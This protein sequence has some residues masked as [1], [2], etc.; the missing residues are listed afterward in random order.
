MTGAVLPVL[1]RTLERVFSG[2]ASALFILGAR[3]L[4]NANGFL[5]TAIVAYHYGLGAVGTL[6][7]ATVP[8][9][10][11]ALFGTFGLPFRFAQINISHA[12]CNS[13]G[14][15]SAAISLPLVLVM[16]A[17]FGLA[18]G[19]DP[20]E[21]FNLAAL[22]FSA[23]FF[24]QTNV[25][26]A[27]QVLQ[28]REAQSI[29]APALNAIGLL[30]GALMPDFTSF[31]ISVL[32]FR[33]AGIVLPYALLPHDFSVIGKAVGHLR[34]GMRYLLS[35][36]VLVLS[37]TLILL[38]TS[39]ILGR[40]DLGILGICRQFLTASD[41]PGWA[42][43]Q[44][45]YPRLVFRDDGYL[46]TLMKS[47]L[48]LGA[49]LGA[50]VTILAIPAGSAVFKVPDLWI[51][52]AILMASVPARYLILSIETYLKAK[53]EIAFVSGLTALRAL[54]ALVVVYVATVFGGLLGHVSAVS[55][56][57][58]VFAVIEFALVSR[59]GMSRVSLSTR[60]GTP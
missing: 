36:A 38:L 33:L 25:T 52:V 19:H 60:E 29:I 59:T 45:L 17:A 12:A 28:R 54:A 22:A 48:R 27:L 26:S 42:N 46:R 41:T 51:Y 13:L 8:T 44:S 18:F 4:Q 32:A 40:S 39:H 31:C 21:Q 24:A 56:F 58:F 50:L 7:L 53:R 1:N 30:V 16:A 43:L 55:A 14:L 47:M 10:V 15:F 49:I 35:D 34:A 9:T 2:G 5:M 37:D 20:A 57:F 6:T 3:L 11:V 23:P